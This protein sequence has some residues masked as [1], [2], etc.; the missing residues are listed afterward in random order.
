MQVPMDQVAY[1]GWTLILHDEISLRLQICFYLKSGSE[2]PDTV[3]PLKELVIKNTWSSIYFPYREWYEEY[4]NLL[5]E[6]R[7]NRKNERVHGAW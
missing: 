3:P 6:N 7:N 1:N 5:D 2:F 4:K